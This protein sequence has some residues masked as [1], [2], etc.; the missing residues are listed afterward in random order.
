M[1]SAGRVLWK[2]RDAHR[3]MMSEGATDTDFKIQHPRGEHRVRD[4][5]SPQERRVHADAGE[6]RNP[7]W[8]ELQS[9]ELES[10][11]GRVRNEKLKIKR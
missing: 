3:D 11:H 6:A 2:V 4:D 10:G 1:P 9:C 5:G 8:K 7:V